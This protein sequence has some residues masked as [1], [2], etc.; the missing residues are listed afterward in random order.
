MGYLHAT[1][2]PTTGITGFVPS[3]VHTAHTLP[4][5][6]SFS[7]PFV[8]EAWVDAE[9]AGI[10][11]RYFTAQIRQESGFNPNAVSPAGAIGIAQ[12]MP[13]TAAGLGLDPTDPHASLRA[14]A[15]YMAQ[16]S[17]KYQGNYAL[18]LAAYNAGDG[19]VQSAFLRCGNTWLSCTP[20][21]TQNYVTSILQT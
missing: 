8:K 10:P 15:E 20:T 21:E 14:A 16:E 12:F 19:A 1:T 3:G 7:T 18:A 9:A 6:L 13:G 2:S 5:G 17:A 11:P 4:A